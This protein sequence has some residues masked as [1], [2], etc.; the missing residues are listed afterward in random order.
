MLTAVTKGA[1]SF[2]GAQHYRGG[3]AAVAGEKPP[4]FNEARWIKTHHE[5]MRMFFAGRIPPLHPLG[6]Q[7]YL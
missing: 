6:F 3:G 1:S 7:L 5:Y 4:D 2:P